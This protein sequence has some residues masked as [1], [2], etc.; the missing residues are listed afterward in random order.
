MHV[1]DPRPVVKSV[2]APADARAQPA[3]RSPTRSVHARPTSRAAAAVVRHTGRLGAATRSTAP[4]VPSARSPSS[5]A[6]SRAAPPPVPAGNRLD[7]HARSRPPTVGAPVEGDA[8]SADAG[9]PPTQALAA[10]DRAQEGRGTPLVA[11][12]IGH[13][14][15]SDAVSPNLRRATGRRRPR[16]RSKVTGDDSGPRPG[17]APGGLLV[18]QLTVGGTARWGAAGRARSR[19]PAN[20]TRAAGGDELDGVRGSRLAAARGER[21]ARKVAGALPARPPG[22]PWPRAPRS[23]LVSSAKPP[24]AIREGASAAVTTRSRLARDRV[25]ASRTAS[26][27]AHKTADP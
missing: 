12:G 9:P 3:R 5:T 27:S 20:A 13:D 10:V 25:A 24:R 26:T 16:R 2:P 23:W 1:R 6:S 4:G 7:G 22:G 17:P 8:Q 15:W 11:G 21:A 19:R 18:Q 14:D